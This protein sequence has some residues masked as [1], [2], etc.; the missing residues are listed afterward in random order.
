MCRCEVHELLCPAHELRIGSGVLWMTHMSNNASGSGPAR[1]TGPCAGLQ[2]WARPPW[3][4]WAW[5][6]RD[7]LGRGRPPRR[8]IA[9]SPTFSRV[10]GPSLQSQKPDIAL[11][12]KR[13]ATPTVPVPVAPMP[14]SANASKLPCPRSAPVALP[15]G[16]QRPQIT[17][18]CRRPNCENPEMAMRRRG[19]RPHPSKSRQDNAASGP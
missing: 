5:P 4:G 7:L 2:R 15:V 14:P 12:R 19:G 1:T 9:T 16:T 13:A 17:F 10:R 8:R 18:P 6:F 3:A 11:R